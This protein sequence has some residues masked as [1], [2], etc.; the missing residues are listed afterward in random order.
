MEP[1]I[2]KDNIQ[3][4]RKQLDHLNHQR[5]SL[6]FSIAHGKPMIHGMLHEVFRKCGKQNCKCTEGDLHGPYPALSV[7]KKGKQRIVMVK[8]A[9]TPTTVRKAKRYRYY[10]QTLV[11]I[12]RI[13]KEI[14][15]LLEKMKTETVSNYP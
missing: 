4:L 8:K 3:S 1:R 12:R 13:N 5:T 7:N 2:N 9:D 15:S 10:Q 14:D 6:I 11:R